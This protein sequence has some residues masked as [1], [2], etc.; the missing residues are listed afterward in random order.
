MRQQLLRARNRRNKALNREI[1]FSRYGEIISALK[2]A[3]SIIPNAHHNIE[4]ACACA[5]PR[6]MKPEAL[7]A[8]IRVF[9]LSKSA[10]KRES[11]EGGINGKR[12][13]MKRLVR[14]PCSVAQLVVIEITKMSEISATFKWLFEAI[15]PCLASDYQ[16]QRETA[17]RWRGLCDKITQRKCRRHIGMYISIV[18]K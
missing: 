6:F 8:A 13:I 5:R 9:R 12:C 18:I 15:G 3:V 7:A 11:I 17:L 14:G 10:L 1:S 2:P 4:R 16:Q